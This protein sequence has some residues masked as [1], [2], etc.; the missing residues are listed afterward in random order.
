M[1]NQ[2]KDIFLWCLR[3]IEFGYQKATDILMVY[4]SEQYFSGFKSTISRG[5][6]LDNS[7]QDSICLYM[8]DYFNNVDL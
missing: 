3:N 2:V 7:N 6:S 4:L 8:K 1:N 5:L